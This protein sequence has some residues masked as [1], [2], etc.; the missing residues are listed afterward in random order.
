MNI[1][2]SFAISVPEE[3]GQGE[4]GERDDSQQDAR[5]E[6]GHVA[7]CHAD[8]PD[9]RHAPVRFVFGSADEHVFRR[10]EQQQLLLQQATVRRRHTRVLRL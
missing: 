9:D 5:D 1:F 8:G 2:F 4:H 10:H 6:R 3:K 7:C